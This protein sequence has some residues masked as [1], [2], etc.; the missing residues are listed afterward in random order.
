MLLFQIPIVLTIGNTLIWSLAYHFIV[1]SVTAYCSPQKV[2]FF[3]PGVQ[4]A[5]ILY[6]LVTGQFCSGCGI[7]CC[8]ESACLRKANT[9]LR[10]KEI[11]LTA[12]EVEK[13]HSVKPKS[14]SHSQSRDQNSITQEKIASEE[15][16]SFDTS[17]IK[18]L[19]HHWV[20]GNLP[21][22]SGYF[23]STYLIFFKNKM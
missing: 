14:R 2:Y 13:N 3:V 21:L 18:K 15:N 5:L 9:S 12:E 19:R 16:D 20:A 11:A 23:S 1:V 6:T 22:N 8:T 7:G 17:E 4:L 10:C